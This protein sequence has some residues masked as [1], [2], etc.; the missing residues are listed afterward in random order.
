M[1]VDFSLLYQD[2]AAT[3]ISLR[4]TNPE[5][6]FTLVG[7]RMIVKQAAKPRKQVDSLDNWQS[8]FHT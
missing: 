6:E 7:D 5:L 3:V 4:D 2:N 8:A 1:Y